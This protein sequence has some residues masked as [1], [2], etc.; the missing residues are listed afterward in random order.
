MNADDVQERPMV[1]MTIDGRATEAR[2]GT[3][4]LEA[5]RGAGVAIPT[6]C[7]HPALEP[8]GGCRLCVVDVTRPEWDGWRKLVISCQYPVEDGLVVLTDTER[9]IETRRVVLDLLLARC[10]ETPLIQQLAREYGIVETSY[11]RNPEP[12][13]CILCAL[14]TRVCDHIGVSAIAIGFGGDHDRLLVTDLAGGHGAGDA[15][16]VHHEAFGMTLQREMGEH[17]LHQ[18]RFV[19]VGKTVGARGHPRISHPRTR[20]A[21]ACG[22]PRPCGAA[23]PSARDPRARGRCSGPPRAP[24]RGGSTRRTSWAG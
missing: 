13:D 24:P 5:A 11:Q 6:L 21:G 12:T 8:Y 14:C 16:A 18:N 15:R 19:D 7:H 20:R 10:P 4:V 1:A 3:F 23:S 22:T 9:V 17:L 2:A